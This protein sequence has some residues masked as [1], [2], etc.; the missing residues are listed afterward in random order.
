VRDG[1]VR[2]QFTEIVREKEPTNVVGRAR[3]EGRLSGNELIGLFIDPLST[4]DLRLQKV[5]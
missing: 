5:K 4:A 3:G 1:E 2:W